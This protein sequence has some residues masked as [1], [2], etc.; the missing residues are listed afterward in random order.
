MTDVVLIPCGPRLLALDRDQ[1]ERALRRGDEFMP[2]SA[3]PAG[4]GSNEPL[5]TAA[6]IAEQS[7]IP[8]S[9]FERQARERRIPHRK[10]GRYVRFVLAEV[11]ESETFRRAAIPPGGAVVGVTGLHDRSVKKT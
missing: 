5:L 10:L 7:G 8:K 9:W 11:T 3:G 4:A 1:F 6:E 2:P